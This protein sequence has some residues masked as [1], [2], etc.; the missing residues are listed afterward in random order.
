MLTAKGLEV[1]YLH[2]SIKSFI[3]YYIVHL[4]CFSCIH[5]SDRWK[6]LGWWKLYL[7]MWKQVWNFSFLHQYWN[8][9]SIAF[10]DVCGNWLVRPSL[11]PSLIS[12]LTYAWK[13]MSLVTFRGSNH[14]LL[15]TEIRCVQSTHGCM[16][17]QRHGE[18]I[19]NHCLQ[20]KVIRA[21]TR[22]LQD[23]RMIVT[24]DKA[25]TFCEEYCK[26]T[27]FAYYAGS[28]VL[29]FLDYN[30]TNVLIRIKRMQIK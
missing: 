15:A 8:K 12:S 17:I 9:D 7:I 16:T 14:W 19:F 27:C 28:Q 24:A 13:E 1:L 4:L 26:L 11:V 6:K 29:K 22:T 30:L 18:Q 3:L 2:T 20:Y 25:W 5:Y 10:H 23:T 21:V